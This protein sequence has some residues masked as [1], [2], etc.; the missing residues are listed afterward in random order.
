MLSSKAA[1]AQ[2]GARDYRPGGGIK[3]IVAGYES[4]QGQVK[5]THG[6]RLR[7]MCPPQPSS[8][9]F[10]FYFLLFASRV[11]K[12]VNKQ[13]GS[14]SWL[15]IFLFFHIYLYFIKSLI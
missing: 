10:L 6:F 15:L 14:L 4:I 7:H 5:W 1:A 11:I 13:E 12:S 9:F 3:V 8:F 2:L